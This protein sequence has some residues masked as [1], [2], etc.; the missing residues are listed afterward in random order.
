MLTGPILTD[1]QFSKEDI[2]YACSELSGS[3][4]S[5]PDGVPA[6]HLNACRNELSAP[7]YIF[8]G[9][10]PLCSGYYT[11]RPAAGLHQPNSQG[12][13]QVLG[14]VLFLIHIRCITARISRGTSSSS[15]ADGTR[16]WRG[17][18]SDEECQLLQTDLQCV[19]D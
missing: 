1:I 10:P 2:E 7:L 13:K 4:S 8:C 6:T 9:E 3:S 18:R 11:P 14:P 5:G 17:V 12:W 15:F 16:V 19:Y